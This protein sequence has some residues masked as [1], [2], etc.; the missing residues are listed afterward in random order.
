MQ[1]IKE[2]KPVEN[3]ISVTIESLIVAGW[4]GRDSAKVSHHIQELAEIGVPAPSTVPLFYQC[5]NSLLTQ[6]KT[7]QALGNGSSG[8]VEPLIIKNN[9]QLYLGL[10]SD[11]TDRNL[12]AYSVAHS[13]QIC[14]KPVARYLWLWKDVVAHLD[15]LYLQSWIKENDQWLTYQEGELS[16]ILPLQE[17]I[18]R[19]ELKNNQAMLCGTLGAIGGVRVAQ[20]FKMQLKDKQLDRSIEASYQVQNLAVIS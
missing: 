16:N 8:E 5:S 13:K 7:I 11:H 6:E 20:G 2:N 12:E 17:L 15:N 18:E 3:S 1:S 14:A 10:G 4:T 9:N 19:A